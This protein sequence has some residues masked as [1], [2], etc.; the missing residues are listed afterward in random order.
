M[1]VCL[2]YKQSPNTILQTT[3]PPVPTAHRGDPSQVLPRDEEVHQSPVSLPGH[4]RHRRAPHLPCHH[5]EECF[6][7]PQRLQDGRGALQQAGEG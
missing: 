2:K 5:R 4:R 3:D 6:R 1:K 7:F